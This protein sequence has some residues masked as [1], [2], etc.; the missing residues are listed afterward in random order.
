MMTSAKEPFGCP[1]FC[2]NGTVIEQSGGPAPGRESHSVIHSSAR[3]FCAP[4]APAATAHRTQT[5][6]DNTAP[7]THPL[8]PIGYLS[9]P[10]ALEHPRPGAA[11]QVRLPDWLHS[12]VNIRLTRSNVRVLFRS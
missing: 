1:W 5:I 8:L 9:C 10:H 6:S 2:Q 3:N 4:M 7:A 12:G 11:R